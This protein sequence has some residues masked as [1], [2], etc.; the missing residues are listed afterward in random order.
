MLGYSTDINDQR[1]LQDRLRQVEKMEAL[2]RLAGGITHDFSNVLVAVNGFGQLALDHLPPGHPARPHVD[3]IMKASQTAQHLVRQI[4]AFSRR[5][6]LSPRRID[7]RAAVGEWDGMIRRLLGSRFD[8][9]IDPSSN[10]PAVYADPGQLFQVV[11]NLS[12]NA[13][14]AMPDGGTI[15]L[16]TAGRRAKAPHEGPAAEVREW[17]LIEIRDTG[18]GMPPEVLRH[19]FEPFY[20][21][22][23][24][25]NGTGLGLATVHGIVTQ[26]GGFLEVESEVGEGTLFRIHLPTAP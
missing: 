23:T 5:Q 1:T 26:S 22:K 20:T 4:V 16:R 19:V 18:T 10:A 13:R 21:T 25:G 7:L 14:D 8:F 9:R 6:E 17:A 15:S 24:E 3:E 11:L 12:I 2:G